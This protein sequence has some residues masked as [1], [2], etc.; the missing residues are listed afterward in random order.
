VTQC[1]EP[2]GPSLSVR[3]ADDVGGAPRIEISG[4]LPPG[5]VA[6]VTILT[7]AATEADGVRPLSEHV[8]LHLRYG[9]EGPDRHVLLLLGEIV[10][11]YA[12][13]DPTDTVAGSAAEVVVHPAYRRRGYGRLLVEAA[14]EQTPDGRLRLWAHGDHPAARR[15]A[16]SMGFR[17]VRRLEQLRRSLDPPLLELPLPETVRVRAFRPGADDAAWLALNA[18]AFARHPE[19]GNWTRR[20]LAARMRES[21]FDPEGFLIAEEDGANGPRM[22]AFHWTKIHGGN[23][24]GSGPGHEDGPGHEGGPGHLLEDGA[25][26][27]A[28][29]AGHETI[30]HGHDPI[31]E[32]YVVGVDPDHQRRGLGRSITVAGLRWL[33]DRGLPQAMLYVEADN[34]PAL[35]V[36]RGLGFTRWDTDVMFYRAG[37]NRV[38]NRDEPPG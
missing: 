35:E 10:V 23:R 29:E 36:Y 6:A 24:P 38:V 25:G 2:A 33:R 9:G 19:Q 11:G 22:V 8:S 27:P 26:R 3:P 21:W 13:L 4:A 14:N 17:V 37:S 18:R 7:E 34:R 5:D 20:D 1:N 30:P 28:T 32:V 31:G 16:E 12:H 15:L